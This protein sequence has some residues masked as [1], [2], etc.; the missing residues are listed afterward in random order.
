M[1]NDD[2]TTGLILSRREALTLI[3]AIGAGELL[4]LH[5]WN[6]AGAQVAISTSLSA[7]SVR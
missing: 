7:T 1:E 3:G 4:G 2:R 6:T 5:R